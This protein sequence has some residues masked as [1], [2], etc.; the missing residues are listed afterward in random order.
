MS[1]R[2][3]QIF[4]T[5]LNQDSYFL[6]WIPK[7]LHE[8]TESKERRSERNCSRDE[9]TIGLALVTRVNELRSMRILF[10]ARSPTKSVY[11]SP[12]SSIRREGSR[13]QCR[14]SAINSVEL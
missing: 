12:L 7:E 9:F 1:A 2:P 13:M 5:L 8:K 4:A 14:N 6:I 3:Q 11:V 10:E